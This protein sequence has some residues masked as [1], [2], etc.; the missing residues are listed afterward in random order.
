MK[1]TLILVS[2]LVALNGVTTVAMARGAAEMG[3]QGPDF[4][5]LDVNGDGVLTE[6]DITDGRDQRFADLDAD[7]DG[8][9]SEEE[10]VAAAVTKAAERAAEGFARLDADGDGSLSRDAIEARQGRGGEMMTRMLNRADADADGSVTEEEFAAFFDEMSS[11][12][13][14]GGMGEGRRG[15]GRH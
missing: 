13:G 2:A 12:R 4:S 6:S 3:R 1:K 7:G 5:M 11:R 9:I 15:F 10:F 14:G 8:M